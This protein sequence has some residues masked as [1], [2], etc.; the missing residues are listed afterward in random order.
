MSQCK[1][2]IPI[3]SYRFKYRTSK[4][5]KTQIKV[6]CQSY[7]TTYS[8]RTPTNSCGGRGASSIVVPPLPG[9][10]CSLL[11]FNDCILCGS[12]EH[13]K[14]HACTS[15]IISCTTYLVYISWKVWIP[16]EEAILKMRGRT[17]VFW[18]GFQY[19]KT[20]ILFHFILPLLFYFTFKF[21]L[22][23]LTDLKFSTSCAFSGHLREVLLLVQRFSRP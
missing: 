11:W 10:S 13:N 14:I 18:W 21:N 4:A 2:H 7:F 12:T 23:Y 9:V 22:I 6:T 19:K 1:R 16:V 3:R 15:V 8:M 20:V 5:G 17:H